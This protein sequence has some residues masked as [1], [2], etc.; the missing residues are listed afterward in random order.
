MKHLSPPIQLMA[1]AAC[2]LLAVSAPAQ[3]TKTG[4]QITRL[5]D[6]LKVEINGHLFTEYI[7][8]D[9]PRPYCYP[10]N[11]PGGLPMMRQWPMKDVPGEEHDHPH[12]RS[13]WFTHGEVN[14]IDFW[15]EGKDKGKIVHAGI[16]EVRSGKDFGLIKTKNNW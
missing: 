3:D 14:G 13:M 15:T 12:H 4:V 5:K 11:G 16:D 10:L 2:G 6:R 1:L 9:T 7:Y 8:E